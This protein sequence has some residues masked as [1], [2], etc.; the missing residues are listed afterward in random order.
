M[1]MFRF[2][3]TGKPFSSKTNL[4]IHRGEDPMDPTLQVLKVL[5]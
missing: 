3:S 4:L 5:K 1:F 2:I